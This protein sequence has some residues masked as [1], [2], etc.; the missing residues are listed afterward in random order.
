VDRASLEAH[1]LALDAE[2]R[3]L[4]FGSSIGDD[5]VREYIARI[6]FERDGV[7]AVDDAEHRLLAVAHVA[8]TGA[9]A[10]LGLSV[11]DGYRGHGFGNALLKHAV[12]HL[13]NRGTRE[14]F[15]HCISENGA[16]LHLARKHGMRLV[17]GGSE[18]DGRLSLDP[19]DAHSYFSEWM[20]EVLRFYFSYSVKVASQSSPGWRSITSRR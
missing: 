18:I 17:N 2:D 15:M 4:R 6:D 16:M 3:R 19:P 20:H 1:F 5:A 12:M 11:L 8:F 14:I 13:R 10:E 7:F 9:S